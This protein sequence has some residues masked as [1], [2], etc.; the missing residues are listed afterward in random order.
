MYARSLQTILQS[1]LSNAIEGFYAEEIIASNCALP[2]S[3]GA[4]EVAAEVATLADDDGKT[5]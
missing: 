2:N 1:Y 4:A 3:D 5:G